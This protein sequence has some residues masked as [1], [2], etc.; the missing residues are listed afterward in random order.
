[1]SDLALVEA[2]LSELFSFPFVEI[3]PGGPNPNHLIKK[4]AVE[5]YDFLSQEV[6]NYRQGEFFVYIPS[7]TNWL[8]PETRSMLFD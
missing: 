2:L 8:S 5:A 1:T 4:L 3:E 7:S 6:Q